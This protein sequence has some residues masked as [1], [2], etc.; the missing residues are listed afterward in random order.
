MSKVSR[1]IVVGAAVFILVAGVITYSVI[2]SRSIAVPDGVI[3][4]TAGNLL[5]K[6]LF[7]ES[8]GVV[9]FANPY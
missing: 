1:W 7:C 4:N 3:G 5:N 2:K 9:Y 8:D 6:G